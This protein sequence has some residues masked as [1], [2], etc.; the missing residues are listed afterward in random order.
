[1]AT[2]VI[3]RNL[4]LEDQERAAGLVGR[5]PEKEPRTGWYADEFLS[6]TTFYV[7]VL[8][9]PVFPRILYRERSQLMDRGI[10]KM[11]R[12]AFAE[13]EQDALV[14]SLAAKSLRG[15]KMKEA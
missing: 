1:M 8:G 6:L 5:G 2:L 13:G 7:H 3:N 4:S 10:L 14:R 11:K 9:V 15:A 12:V